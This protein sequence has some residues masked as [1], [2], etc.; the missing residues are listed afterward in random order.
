[1]TIE[2]ARKILKLSPSQATDE[3]IQKIIDVLKDLARIYLN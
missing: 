1:M 2:K 3:M